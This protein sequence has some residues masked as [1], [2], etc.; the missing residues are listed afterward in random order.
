MIHR[1]LDDQRESRT[2]GLAATLRE[3]G[4]DVEVLAVDRMPADNDA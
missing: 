2:A 4:M 3:A 1:Y